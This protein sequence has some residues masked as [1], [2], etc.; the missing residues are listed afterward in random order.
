MSEMFGNNSPKNTPNISVESVLGI[1]LFFSNPISVMKFGFR[2]NQRA[3]LSSETK[4]NGPVDFG[5]ISH[6][7]SNDKDCVDSRQ[8]DWRMPYQIPSESIA[9]LTTVK[10]TNK[11]T[12]RKLPE[13]ELA[14][15]AK[16]SGRPIMRAPIPRSKP[17]S[18]AMENSTIEKKQSSASDSILASVSSEDLFEDL[19]LKDSLDDIM[20]EPRDDAPMTETEVHPPVSAT[21]SSKSSISSA[22]DRTPDLPIHIDPAYSKKKGILIVDPNNNGKLYRMSENNKNLMDKDLII[23]NGKRSEDSESDSRT[24]VS[25]LTEVTYE[26]TKEEKIALMMHQFE[27]VTGPNTW[28]SLLSCSTLDRVWEEAP[29]IQVPYGS[30]NNAASGPRANIKKKPTDVTL[31]YLKSFFSIATRGAC[32]VNLGSFKESISVCITRVYLTVHNDGNENG[33]KCTFNQPKLAHDLG[34]R[35]SEMSDGRA[36]VTEV[37]HDS[38]AMRSGVLPGDILSVS[39]RYIIWLNI[40]LC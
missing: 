11:S 28:C 6:N 15:S 33:L 20:D 37:F 24:Q 8:D 36:V 1:N 12:A 13:Y 2:K 17:P 3:A 26:K 5:T 35:L 21:V 22:S 4:K 7:D 39:E 18:S 40:H 25:N 30:I 29:A 16:L 23:I 38:G 10:E 34:V 19:P 32:D 31:S 14:K 9:S 27:K